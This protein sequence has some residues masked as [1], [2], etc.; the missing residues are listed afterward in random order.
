MGYT[1]A[2][3]SIHIEIE[4][5]YCLIHERVWTGETISI[6]CKRYGLSRKSHEFHLDEDS[7][8]TFAGMAAICAAKV[9]VIPTAGQ[10]FIIEVETG[11]VDEIDNLRIT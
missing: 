1:S 9:D 10:Q 2:R 3:K 11:K 7:D 4:R 6:I 8:Q 5:R